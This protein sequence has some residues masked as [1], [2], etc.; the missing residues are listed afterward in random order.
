VPEDRLDGDVLLDDVDT[1]FENNKQDTSII[2]K[3][4]EPVDSQEEVV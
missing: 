2:D 3:V 4:F 1:Y